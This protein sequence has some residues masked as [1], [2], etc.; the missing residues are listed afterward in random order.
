MAKVPVGSS[1][2]PKSLR[3]LLAISPDQLGRVDIARANL[4][5]AEGL[6]GAE[7]VNVNRYLSILYLWAKRIEVLT[8]KHLDGFH[9]NPDQ[10]ENSEAYW[11]TLALTTVLRKEFNVRYKM[12]RIDQEDWSD[13]R[14]ILIH[15]LLGPNR[16]GTCTSL[17]GLSRTLGSL[18]WRGKG[19]FDKMIPSRDMNV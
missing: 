11:R 13:S 15:G 8:G 19:E 1:L 9:R 5:C 10:Y 2:E 17:P 16:T 18:G 6:P 3:E 12:E 4:L 7:D 14:D